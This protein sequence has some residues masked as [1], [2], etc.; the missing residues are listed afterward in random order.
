MKFLQI[1]LLLTFSLY[2]YGTSFAALDQSKAECIRQ[3]GR[4]VSQMENGK[5]IF[6]TKYWMVTCH[7]SN[8]KC[9]YVSYFLRPEFE[10]SDEIFA[11]MMLNHGTGWKASNKPNV[12]VSLEGYYSITNHRI[13]SF[14]TQKYLR[15]IK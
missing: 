3:F 1:S 12:A 9:D 5:F 13:L 6:E 15:Q 8:D 2:F 10:Y 4:P 11:Q 7:F 14:C